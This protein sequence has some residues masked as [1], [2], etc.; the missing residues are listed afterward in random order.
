MEFTILKEF[1]RGVIFYIKDA[2]TYYNFALTCKYCAELAREYKSYKMNEFSE[3]ITIFDQKSWIYTSRDN[4]VSY[5]VLPNGKVHGFVY[6]P[7]INNY[8][9]L[10]RYKNGVLTDYIDF[11]PPTIKS[12]FKGYYFDDDIQQQK[13]PEHVKLTY[14]TT[15]YLCKV[16]ANRFV[17][18]HINTSTITAH[19]CQICKQ[20]HYFNLDPDIDCNFSVIILLRA[21]NER[22]YT[23]AGK[24]GD[25]N[26]GSDTELEDWKDEKLF[27]KIFLIKK[28]YNKYRK[29][30]L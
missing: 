19:K 7:N 11:K 5:K 9:I 15:N 13:N 17:S 16:T 8:I 23:F 28:L 4:F 2:K 6:L 3:S 20:Y 25:D 27:H 1:L 26:Y 22:T 12:T 14:V 21:C 18:I 24:K 30:I 29:K 10:E